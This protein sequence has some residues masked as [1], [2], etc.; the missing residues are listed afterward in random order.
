[1]GR[2]Q[3]SRDRAQNLNSRRPFIAAEDAIVSPIYVPELAGLD[4]NRIEARPSEELGWIAPRPAYSVLSSERGT[5]LPS[6]EDAMDRYI[7]QYLANRV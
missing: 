7:Q 6:L 4:A 1:L 3:L 5:L 2:L